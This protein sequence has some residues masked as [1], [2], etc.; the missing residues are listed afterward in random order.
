MEDNLGENKKFSA[1]GA[2][3]KWLALIAMTVDHIGYI[4]LPSVAAL[5]I[6]GRISY[7][8]FAYFIAEG[9]FYTKHKLRYVLTM[10]LVGAVCDAT[11]FIFFRSYYGCI[12]TTFTLSALIIFAADFAKKNMAAGNNLKSVLSVIWLLAALAAAVILGCY[13]YIFHSDYIAIDYGLVGALIPVAVW[14]VKDRRLKLAALGVGLLALSIINGG[15]QPFSLFALVP[16]MFYNGE[17]G[18]HPMKYFFYVYYPVHLVI[19]YGIAQ[20]IAGFGG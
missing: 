4:L 20:L 18:K 11:Y 1:S 5:R 15:W 2:L 7:P 19:L 6:I 10:F 14:A 9:C 3:L 13:S 16:L 8:I 12:L 17:R